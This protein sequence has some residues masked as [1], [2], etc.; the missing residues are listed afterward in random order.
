MRFYF[1]LTAI[2]LIIAGLAGAALSFDGSTYLYGILESQAPHAPND[3]YIYIP[4]HLPVLLADRYTDGLAIVRA[5]FGLVYAAIPI[6]ALLL[7]WWVVH[8]QARHLFIWPAISIGLGTLPGQFYLVSEGM[9]V[10]QLAWPIVLSLLLRL[11]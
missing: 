4:L 7:C 3:R 11:P 2:A 6:T 8:D 9:Y 1:A 5:V 10:A